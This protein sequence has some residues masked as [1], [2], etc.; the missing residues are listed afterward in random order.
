MINFIMFAIMTCSLALIEL[1]SRYS[2]DDDIRCFSP[3][4]G[5]RS[6]ENASIRDGTYILI[7]PVGWPQL[8]EVLSVQA[9]LWLSGFSPACVPGCP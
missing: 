2:S 6:A 1:T 8:F 9:T 3:Y 4:V 5:N 7:R